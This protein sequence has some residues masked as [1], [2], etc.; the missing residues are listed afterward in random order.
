MTE[1]SAALTAPHITIE[2][3]PGLE[4]WESSDDDRWR[5]DLFELRQEMERAAPEA[6]SD[7]I[8]APGTK[9]GVELIEIIVALGSA[10]VFS[11]AVEAFKA[12]LAARPSGRR[13]ISVTYTVVDEDGRRRQ[14]NAVIT[15]DNVDSNE[16]TAATGEVFKATV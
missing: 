16:L 13:T 1:L 5:S 7:G 9:K 11:A 10:G 15:G 3:A 2:I 12:W 6:V 8:A 14:G 4:E